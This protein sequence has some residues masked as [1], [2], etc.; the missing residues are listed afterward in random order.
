MLG[1]TCPNLRD[2]P[3]PE[4]DDKPYEGKLAVLTP[5]QRKVVKRFSTNA[6]GEFEA[7]LAPGEYSIR[8][9]PDSGT[10]PACSERQ[11]I[12]VVAH[13]FTQ[14]DVHCDTGIR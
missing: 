3:E 5:D 12:L 2:P 14:A 1:P 9:E 11:P 13:G 10:L 6:H 4:C 8:N 7:A